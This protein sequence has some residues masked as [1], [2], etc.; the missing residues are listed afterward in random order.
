M[1]AAVDYFPNGTV[2]RIE[3]RAAILEYKDP[4]NARFMEM[5]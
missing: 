1:I 5:H 4:A 2:K 3:Y